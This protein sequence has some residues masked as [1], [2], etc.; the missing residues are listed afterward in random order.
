MIIYYFLITIINKHDS[1]VYVFSLA[2]TVLSQNRYQYEIWAV[3]NLPVTEILEN[4]VTL[5]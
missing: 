5:F 3:R 4:I 1:S 2:L